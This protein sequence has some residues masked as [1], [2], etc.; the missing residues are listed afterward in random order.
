MADAGRLDG[1]MGLE[2]NRTE[3]RSNEGTEKE[4]RRR[5]VEVKTE[6]LEEALLMLMNAGR[7]GGIIWKVPNFRVQGHAMMRAHVFLTSVSQ[8]VSV[9]RRLRQNLASGLGLG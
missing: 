8:P 9:Y 7:G 3:G 2:L 6:R 5:W 1:E 4:I